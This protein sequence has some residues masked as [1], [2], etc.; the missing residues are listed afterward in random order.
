MADA[1]ACERAFLAALDGDCR[2]PLAGHAVIAGGRLKF[3]GLIL[4]PD[5]QTAHEISGEGPRRDAAK[6]GAQA[7][8]DVRAKAGP[9][10]FGS[11][12]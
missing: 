5:G 12:L 3:S 4:T 10:F 7:G 11:W 6:I 1:L 2:T 9:G 8:A